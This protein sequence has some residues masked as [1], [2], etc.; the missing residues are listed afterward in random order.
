MED[1]WALIDRES[2]LDFSRYVL[3]DGEFTWAGN[4]SKNLSTKRL[5]TYSLDEMFPNASETGDEVHTF[6]ECDLNG[7][8]NEDKISL[9]YSTNDY[10][11]PRLTIS[12]IEICHEEYNEEIKQDILIYAS[13]INILATKTNGMFDLLADNRNLY[14]WDGRKYK[15]VYWDGK[16]FK[17]TKK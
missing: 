3:K 17:V 11:G 2:S 4:F 6:L 12:E 9:T 7:D 13:A 14:H 10:F 1:S 15:L 5:A 8:G 16:S